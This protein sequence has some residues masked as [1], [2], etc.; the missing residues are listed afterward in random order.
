MK[1]N[2]DLKY[3]S[4][5]SDLLL[6][7]IK[8]QQ[9]NVS[10]KLSDFFYIEFKKVREQFINE[11]VVFPEAYYELVYKAI[12]E[13]AIL[14]EK[15]NY[16]LEHR[17]SGE[18][19]LLGELQ[20]KEISEITYSWM[21]RNLL[22]AIR[23]Q[24]D[25]LI[26]NHWETCHQYYVYCLQYIYEE[27][28]Y[29][30]D[31][32]QVSNKE[33]VNKPKSE[34]QKFI[35][36]HYALGGLLTYKERFSCIKRL[37]N[38][39]QSQPP[40][41]ELLPESMFEIFRFYFDV[42]DPY[43]RKY[44]WISK[45]FPFP[46]LSGLNA[47]NVIKKWIMSYMAILFLRQ[48]TI[49]PYLI[50]IRPLDF[51]TIPNTQGEIKQWIDGL[52]FFK[53][54]VSEHLDNKNMLKTMNLDFI[55]P[56]WCIENQK[57]DPIT[58]IDR[59]KS[60]L[61]SAY[62]TNALTVTI[63]E[64]KITEFENA[65]KTIIEL[66]IEK[67]QPLNN[68]APIQDDN[69]DKWYVNGQRMLQDKD[70]FSKN[71]E[72]HHIDYDKFLATV[73]SRSLNEG[74]GE[75]FL[76][77][78]SKSYL[79]KPEELF[80]AID[81]LSIDENYLIV[82]FGINLDYFIN[83][84]MISGLNIDKYNNIN[85]YSFNGTNNVQDSLFVLKKSDLPNISTKPIDGKIIAKYSLKKISEIINLYSS[86]IDLNNTSFEIFNELKQDKSD[87]DLRKSVL[88]SII[89]STEFK[90]K[91]GIEVIQLRQYSDLFQKGIANKLD[92]VKPIDNEKSSN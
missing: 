65:T 43:D 92:D 61:E 2:T 56:E 73:V 64:E 58:F 57:L 17:T 9:T 76:R 7:S 31:N 71:P 63:S 74:L 83:Q 36:F 60:N 11:P 35:E 78:M 30:G 45:Q 5:L 53:N 59:F 70:A 38:H 86:V 66:A 72:V 27:Y 62:H 88:L 4:A 3:F 42:S 50:T 41:Y 84:L 10:K 12:E 21:W 80:L 87:E 18:I 8:N 52:D 47:D 82:N 24:Q 19:W 13:L 22:L 77:K 16:L 23:Y 29:S 14:K 89:L 69:S 26:V 81:K 68:P 44:T 32:F 75:I 91:R 28:D 55:T 15:R 85:L 49:I 1:D 79:L 67:L 37:F 34:R 40:K 46:D 6:Q 51:P 20:G 90:W 39:T 33:A 48:Y 25:D 54:L